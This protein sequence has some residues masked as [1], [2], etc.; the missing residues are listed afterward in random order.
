MSTMAALAIGLVVLIA[1]FLTGLPVYLSFIL[2]VGGSVMLLF[3][4]AGFGMVANSV[5]AVSTTEALTTVPLFILMGELLMRSGS[6]DVLFS[7]I[8]KLIG[9]VRGRQYHMTLTLSAIL[10][11]PAGSGIA[12]AAMLGRSVMRPM[13]KRGYDVGLSAGVM[14]GGALLAP[15]IPPSVLAIIIGTMTTTVSISDL[16]ISGII[17]GIV[18]TLLYVG[19]V[20]L[21]V[22]ANPALAP[23]EDYVRPTARERVVALLRM[24]PFSLIIV[25]SIG[26]IMFDMATPSEAAA[27]GAMAAFLEA[28]YYRKMKLSDYLVAAADSAVLSAV[29]LVIMASAILFGQILAFTGSIQELGNAIG[30]MHENRWLIFFLMMLLP[31]IMC[32]FVDQIG[33]MMVLIPIYDPLLKPLGFDPVWF[34]MQ[35]L[36]NMVVG[37]ITPPF[38]YV[39]FALKAAVPEIRLSQLFEP[40]WIFT[41]ITVFAMFLF[42]VFPGLITW[43]PEILK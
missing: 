43:L 13:I 1:L 9:R 12:I 3:G 2:I 33:L 4:S 37:A 19:Y 24:I 17:P 21:R 23:Q 35:F 36:I 14:M 7:S 41:G 31:F 39:L 29:V 16:L 26:L 8:D 25:V 22:A 18:L 11:A 38:G 15:I 30:A 32:M 10:G 27:L 20:A 34:W 6:I 28:L 5:Y 40:G 42:T